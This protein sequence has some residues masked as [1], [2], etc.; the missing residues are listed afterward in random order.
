VEAAQAGASEDDVQAQMMARMADTSA[1]RCGSRS[2]QR[3]D[4][5]AAARRVRSPAARFGQV[6]LVGRAAAGL[7]AASIAVS[8]RI[9]GD[10]QAM[11]HEALAAGEPIRRSCRASWRTSRNT[12]RTD[13]RLDR[14]LIVVVFGVLKSTDGPN[15][16]GAEPVRF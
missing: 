8:I 11:M 1:H 14:H 13:D 16:Y 7:Q 15:R 10:M 6:R 12:R 2:P 9:D 5:P 3:G 4:A